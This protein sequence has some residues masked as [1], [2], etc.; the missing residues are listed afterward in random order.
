MHS[1]EKNVCNRPFI[2][3]QTPVK[4]AAGETVYELGSPPCSGKGIKWTDAQF[5][6][7]L[8]GPV[9]AIVLDHEGK[10]LAASIMDI[11]PKEFPSDAVE[12]FIDN[13]QRIT[14]A[15]VGEAIAQA[16][17]T[18]HCQ[19]S[20]PWPPIWDLRASGASLPG[21]DLVGFA[22]DADSGK[23]VMVLGEVKTSAQSRYPPSVIYGKTGLKRQ[24]AD[25]GA[26]PSIRTD[27]VNYLA[28]RA[29][30][31][32]WRQ[33]CKEAINSYLHTANMRIYGVL[34]R[35]VEPRQP[36]LNSCVQA[37]ASVC[38]KKT[39]I[40]LLAIYIPAGQIATLCVRMAS[41]SKE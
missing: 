19:C 7:A 3:M 13:P 25:L 20:F 2:V 10:A 9:A 6:T 8:Q 40:T 34:I 14:K 24:L 15:Q 1:A 4:V 38:S 31:A 30:N 16:Y 18:D 22:P 5:N 35:D 23:K 21:A 32:E 27:L 26:R 39:T 17:L 36:D 11:P 12:N 33:D 41:R 37:L 29:A 28:R